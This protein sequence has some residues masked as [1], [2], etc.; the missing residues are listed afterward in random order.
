MKRWEAL[1][2]T[3]SKILL[4]LMLWDPKLYR[5]W[6][7]Q[8]TEEYSSLREGEDTLFP[9]LLLGMELDAAFVTFLVPK[10]Q[11]LTTTIKGEVYIGSWFQKV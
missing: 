7:P 11:Y 2:N 10:T 3:L 8:R 5:A 1:G 9:R 6:N 4:A